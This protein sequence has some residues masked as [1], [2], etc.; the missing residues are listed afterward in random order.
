MKRVPILLLPILLVQ[1]CGDSNPMQPTDPLDGPVDRVAPQA[2]ADESNGADFNAFPLY[3]GFYMVASGNQCWA[4]TSADMSWPVLD[5]VG[6]NDWF[7]TDSQTRMGHDVYEHRGAPLKVLFEGS[8]YNGMATLRFVEMRHDD[9][10]IMR[11]HSAVGVVLGPSGD[12]FTAECKM[13]IN[14]NGVGERGILIY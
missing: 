11:N 14:K 3:T 13:V 8:E 1:A 2:T 9:E 5:E 7:R 6:Q 4:G 12:E 10:W